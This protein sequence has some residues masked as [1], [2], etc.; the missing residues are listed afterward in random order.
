M[1]V[2]KYRDTEGKLTITNRLVIVQRNIKRVV[3]NEER[4]VLRNA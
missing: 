2:V 3:Q 1:C 4:R